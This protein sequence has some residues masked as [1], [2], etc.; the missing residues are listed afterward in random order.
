MKT[1]QKNSKIQKALQH[2]EKT[3]MPIM[4]KIGSNRYIEAIRNGMISIIPILLIGSTFLILFFFPIGKKETFGINVL[5]NVQDGR[6][7]SFMM[8]PYRLTYPMLGFFAVIGIA[9][10]LAK[11]YKLDDQ[12]GVLI[13]IIAYMISIVGPSY[14]GI[15][16]PTFTTASFGSATVFGGIIVSILAIEVFRACVK[17]KI[18]I[19]MPKSVPNVVA[20]P[21]NA[22]IPMLF[23]MLPS[24]LLFNVLK[25]NLH[26]YINFLFQPLQ[27]I[28]AGSNYIGFIVVVLLIMVL[29]IAGIHG[30]AVIGSLARPFWLIALDHNTNL[31]GSLKVNSLYVKD[32]A[33]ILVEPFFQWFVW[34]GGAGAT[35]G[36]IIVML[37]IAKSKYIRAVTYSSVLPGIFNINEPIIFGYPLVLNPYLALPAILSPIAMGT[38][39]FICMKLNIVPVP[40]Q[41]VGWTLPSPVGA[42]LSTGL[43]WEACVL[44]FILIA[45]S[46]LIWWPF[47]KAY[48]NK[49]L[50]DEIEQEIEQEIATA[51]AENQEFDEIAIR[52]RITKELKGRSIFKRKKVQK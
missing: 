33:N 30:V 6:W 34:I 51:K 46:A 9:R 48:D 38:V 41:L 44:T 23:V 36:L 52:A 43:S 37:L 35:L 40:V 21:F 1:K 27:N 24:V 25:F 8:L 12:Q 39:T 28:F 4:G 5:M 22:L 29:W 26:G 16:N 20:K 3:F 19:R 14:K 7:A 17:Y 42:L 11:S 32:G 49:M 31:L 50:R 45:L 47:A 15:G 18:M 13:A 2:I 10:S